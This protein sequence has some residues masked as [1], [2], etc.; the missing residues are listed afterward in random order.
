[1]IVA[2]VRYRF[3]D[4]YAS[5]HDSTRDV[6]LCRMCAEKHGLVPPVFH[7]NEG[8]ILQPTPTEQIVIGIQAL[9]QELTN[10]E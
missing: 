5:S 4:S 2:S 7:R 1:M 8:V 6:D 9:I 10:T 3:K